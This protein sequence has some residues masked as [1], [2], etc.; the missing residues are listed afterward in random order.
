MRVEEY[1]FEDYVIKQVQAHG[2]IQP[3]DIAKL[4]YQAAFG[5]EHLLEDLDRAREYFNQ[6]YMAVEQTQE[7]LYEQ[8]SQDVCRINM[9]AWKRWGLPKEW[10]FVMFADSAQVSLQGRKLM[11]QYLECVKRLVRQ[12]VFSF[13][14]EQW[15]Q[16][17]QR[18]Q[19]EGM[20]S[21]H[22]SEQYREKN[23]P[24]YRMVN[25]QCIACIPVLQAA[26]QCQEKEIR[27]IAIDGPCASGKSTLAK[28]LAVVLQAGVVHMDDFFVPPALRSKER[29]QEAGGNVH[30]ERFQE[31][32]LPYI[33]R[34]DGFSYRIFDCGSM[35][36]QG[37]RE[38]KTSAWRIVEG[39]YSCH[40]CF[41]AYADI[42]VYSDISPQLQK[43]RIIKRNGAK[44][45]KRFENEWIPMENHYFQT[46]HIKENAEVKINA[47]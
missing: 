43:E 14:D 11:I 44:M 1:V 33:N 4:C 13:S 5:A 42:K 32:V 25:S 8:I 40:T 18:Y 12:G 23:K 10:L 34:K 6:E 35:D 27:V 16:F 36:Y 46:F 31:E 41:G 19:Q 38:I 45:G 15:Q 22:H 37:R 39:S 20:P 28:R 47:G 3:Q 7:P 29:F 17:I 21:L 26:A 9:G 2:T 30:Y 24:S